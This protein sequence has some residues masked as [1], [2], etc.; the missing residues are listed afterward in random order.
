M[1]LTL[2]LWVFSCF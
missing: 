1:I 2:F